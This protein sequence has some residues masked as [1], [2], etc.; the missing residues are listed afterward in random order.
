MD[1]N[2]LLDGM[3]DIVRDTFGQAVSYFQFATDITYP[4]I[5]AIFD[6]S[7]ET[8]EVG[9]SVPVTIR[10]PVLDIKLSDIGGLEP[11]QDD[12]ATI[13]GTK[14]RVIKALPSSSGMMKA[15]L[16]KM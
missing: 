10:I 14:Y 3:T 11:K 12:E 9:G 8:T 6:P 13:N 15:H 16:R 1:W 5:D 4:D 7:F 2:D